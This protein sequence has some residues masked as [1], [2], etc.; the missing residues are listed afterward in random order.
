PDTADDDGDVFD[1]L[2]SATAGTVVPT[3]PQVY[4]N[5]RADGTYPTASRNLMLGVERQRRFV[6]PTDPMGLGRVVAWNRQPLFYPNFLLSYVTSQ[7]LPQQN[8]NMIAAQLGA[9]SWYGKGA[10]SKGRVG[11]FGYY[12]PPG[13]S[14]PEILPPEDTTQTTVNLALNQFTI[15]T[16]I[17]NQPGSLLNTVHGYESYRNPLMGFE[18]EAGNFNGGGFGAAMP[19]NFGNN[20]E[21]GTW[22]NNSPA[23][24]PY[25]FANMQTVPSNK[26]PQTAWPMP[27]LRGTFTSDVASD[28]DTINS[29]LPGVSSVGG[30]MNLDEAD[31]QNLYDTSDQFDTP[32]RATDLADLYLKDTGYDDAN[33]GSTITSRIVQLAPESLGSVGVP[34]PLSSSGATPVEQ[35][36]NRWPVNPRKL[37]SHE[38]WDT[39]RFSWSNDNPGGVFGLPGSVMGN[40]NFGAN[41]SASLPN[42]SSNAFN[43]FLQ[44]PTPSIAA[45]DRRINLNFPLP[46]YDYQ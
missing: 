36:Y 22:P 44:F 6:T 42:L 27:N 1:F 31:E 9:V 12:R 14:T 5:E 46:A 34:Q 18:S 30:L 28:P 8:F 45:G 37:F 40:A 39:N 13:V 4:S 7:G 25:P 43:D 10:D 20:W 41:Q 38:S 21:N 33:T 26:I 15:G 16:N 35:L 11:F 24:I 17:Y 23:I 32:F 2:A 3:A 29:F 19:Y